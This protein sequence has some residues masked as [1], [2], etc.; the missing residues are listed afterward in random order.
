MT[1]HIYLAHDVFICFKLI[2]DP[3]KYFWS[4][5]SLLHSAGIFIKL[6]SVLFKYHIFYFGRMTSPVDLLSLT[7]Q[8]YAFQIYKIFD[9]LGRNVKSF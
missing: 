3:L 4:V 2:P 8:L 1:V 5:I 6:K 9:I 7:K